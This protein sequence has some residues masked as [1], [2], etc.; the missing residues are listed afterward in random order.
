MDKNIIIKELERHTDTVLSF[1][2]RGPWGDSRY[3]GNYFR[4]LSRLKMDCDYFL[5]YGNGCEGHLYHGTVEQQCDEM[6]KLWDALPANEKPEWL[7]ME[8]IKDYRVK[9]LSLRE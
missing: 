6:E 3:R 7:T 5:G 4:M 9:M 1:P 8:G 2:N